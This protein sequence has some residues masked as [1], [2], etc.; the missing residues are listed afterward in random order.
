MKNTLITI[1]IDSTELKKIKNK[2]GKI[3]LSKII[4]IILAKLTKKDLI[5]INKLK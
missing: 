3:K 2:L 5:E 4:R 1:R